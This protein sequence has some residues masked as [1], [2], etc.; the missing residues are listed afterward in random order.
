MGGKLNNEGLKERREEYT[1]RRHVHPWGEGALVP[2][3]TVSAT[4]RYMFEDFRLPF[5][6]TAGSD[7]YMSMYARAY[8]AILSLQVNF[9]CPLLAALARF[10]TVRVLE[11]VPR[12]F[13]G[14]GIAFS[15]PPVWSVRHLPSHPQRHPRIIKDTSIQRNTGRLY[16]G[17]FDF[18]RAA[19]VYNSSRPVFFLFAVTYW[20]GADT[21]PTTAASL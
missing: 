17:G 1:H 20:N 5:S 9:F 15:T 10:R 19:P 4:E 2:S 6:T 16:N 14:T 11:I 13:H 21:H 18:S 12:S 7:A 3:R 8:G